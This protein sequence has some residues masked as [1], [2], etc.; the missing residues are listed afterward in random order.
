MPTEW[1]IIRRADRAVEDDSW[2][3]AFLRAA[4][5]GVLA[6]CVDGQPFT[7]ARN[8]VY[9]AE[10]HRIYLHGARKGRTYET[11]QN[12]AR[13]NFNVSEMGRLLPA[14]EAAEM[15]V[16]YRGVVIFGRVSLVTDPDEARFA[17]QTLVEKYF[18]HLRYG[19]D[20]TPI[21][22]RDLKR[23]AVLR[24]EIESWSGKEKKIP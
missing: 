22:D 23:T 6:T 24:L 14:E 5:Y 21:T 9:D 15:S 2:I 16:E 12:G 7:V 1:T 3:V 19:E 10:R 8:F 17:L 13:A 20:Y 18:P 4:D 11:V